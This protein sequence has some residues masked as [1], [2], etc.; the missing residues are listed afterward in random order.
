MNIKN[1]TIVQDKISDE[2][3]KIFKKL[4]KVDELLLKWSEFIE[5]L[6][7]AMEVDWKQILK[8]KTD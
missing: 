3:Y 1:I 5:I 6:P 8:Q 7:D 2:D 4:I